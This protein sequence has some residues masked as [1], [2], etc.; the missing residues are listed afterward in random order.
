MKYILDSEARELA[1]DTHR[2]KAPIMYLS[3][4]NSFPNSFASV[5]I[6]KQNDLRYPLAAF[7]NNSDSSKFVMTRLQSGRYSLKPNLRERGFLFR[8]ESEFHSPCRPNLFRRFAPVRFTEEMMKGQE[9][10]LLILSHPL[11]QLL[12]TGIEI[13]GEIVRFEMNL[14]GL[15]QHYYNKTSLLD[16]TSNPEIAMFFATTE[17]DWNTDTY[18][19]IADEEHN[20]GVLYFYSLD[21]NEDFKPQLNDKDSS[22]RT[23][24]LQ[25]FPRSGRQ[26]GFIYD[27]KKNED[28]NQTP[29]LK[30]FQFKHNAAKATEIFD[31]FNGGKELFPED[32][33]SQHW[34]KYNN[35]NKV[36]SNRTV[37]LNQMFNQRQ[38]IGEL[39]NEISD[40]GYEIIDYQPSFTPEELN[41]YYANAK[42][43]WVEFCNQIHI[44]GDDGTMMQ[45][46]LDIP[47]D[48]RYRWAFEPGHNHM[49][50]YNHGFILKKYQ[51][52]LV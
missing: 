36:I 35:G 17:Y 23:I 29:R 5:E 16:L 21:I 7:F 27:V 19:P 43:N 49:I 33:L 11:V 24:G 50:D 37:M 8:G 52:C 9:M 20:P 2:Q 51:K 25:V 15:T 42:E 3:K 32:I 10:Y 1:A 30:S 18:T 47:N 44:P 13:N 12:D 39:T 31:K 41:T 26:K 40:L 38:T 34:M 14:W 48:Q 4:D 45:A 28:F 46:M 22:L 6:I